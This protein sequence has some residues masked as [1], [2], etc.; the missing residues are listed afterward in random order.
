MLIRQITI[1]YTIMMMVL[2]GVP[3]ANAQGGATLSDWKF[4]ETISGDE[5]TASALEGKVVVVEYWGIR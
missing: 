2:V 3:I 5:P 1:I 4:L